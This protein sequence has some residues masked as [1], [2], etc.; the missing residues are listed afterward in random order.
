MNLLTDCLI[1]CFV[2]QMKKLSAKCQSNLAKITE[3]DYD[4]ISHGPRR[5]DTGPSI[6]GKGENNVK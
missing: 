1:N 4:N 6:W 2:L 5:Q 3:I